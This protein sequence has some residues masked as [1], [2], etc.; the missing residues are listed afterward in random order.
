M[1]DPSLQSSSFTHYHYS[2]ARFIDPVTEKP[3]GENLHVAVNLV[4]GRTY[5]MDTLVNMCK[6]TGSYRDLIT[7]QPFTWSKHIVSVQDPNDP[8]ARDVRSFWYVKE[9]EKRRAMGEKEEDSDEDIHPL[10]GGAASSSSKSVPGAPRTNEES[11]LLSASAS[12]SSSRYNI[13][14][15]MNL[16]DSLRNV[17]AAQSVR[18]AEVRGEQDAK[19]RKLDAQTA[20][21][22]AKANTRTTNTLYTSGAAGR[23]FTSTRM[24]TVTADNVLRKNTDEEER[25]LV[26]NR[27]KKRKKNCKGYV[28]LELGIDT[29]TAKDQ[30]LGSLNVELHCDIAPRACDNFMRHC[31]SGYYTGLLFHRLVEN[32]VLQGGCPEGTGRGG[33]SAFEE[34]EPTNMNIANRRR[35]EGNPFKDEFDSRLN[36][37]SR[38]VLAMANAGGRDE[39]KSQFFFTLRGDLN[40]TLQ[41]KHTIFGRVVGGLSL[42]DSVNT[43]VE[44]DRTKRPINKLFIRSVAIFANPFEDCRREEQEEA[45]K[46]K[47][48]EKKGPE[49][50]FSNRMDPMGGHEKR[51]DTGVGKYVSEALTE[52]KSKSGTS[53]QDFRKMLAQMPPEEREY[54]LAGRRAEKK[55]KAF[56]FG[57]GW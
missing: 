22:E 27:V 19:R 1:I 44:V 57:E 25:I 32:F 35:P 12:S 7:E 31:A 40:S 21:K 16:T 5:L 20:E 3:F 4:S 43:S 13:E 38:G 28:K 56:E 6:K 41:N 8:G 45:E 10:A 30:S 37:D 52:S 48:E 15:N 49:Q 42:L 23:S 47:A 17:L 2:P 51:N 29:D 54:A 53:E 50:W 39:N 46:K 33:R 24:T 14:K 11:L 55:R 36:F 18:V 9:S 26:Y 34:E